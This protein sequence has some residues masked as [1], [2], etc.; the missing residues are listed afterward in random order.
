M[1]AD[2]TV[3]IILVVVVGLA[4]RHLIKRRKSGDRCLGCSMSGNCSNCVDTSK[5]KSATHKSTT[6]STNINKSDKQSHNDVE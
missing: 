4:V 3:I 5:H 1:I 6:N 2:L